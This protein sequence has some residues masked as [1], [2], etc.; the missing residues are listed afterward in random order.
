MCNDRFSKAEAQ[1]LRLNDEPRLDT[2]RF[3]RN[4]REIY[5]RFDDWKGIDRFYFIPLKLSMTYCISGHSICMSDGPV[6]LGSFIRNTI[7]HPELFAVTCPKCGRKLNPFSFNGSPLSGRVDLEASCECGWDSF[8]TVTG[9]RVRSE[10]L[11]ATQKADAWR[12][13]SFK[14]AGRK[15]A[16]IQELLEWLNT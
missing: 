9:W 1:A 3:F 6:Y 12:L 16:S 5:R 8:V 13:G 7:E 15:A 14:F 11:R 4:S 2:I 10:A